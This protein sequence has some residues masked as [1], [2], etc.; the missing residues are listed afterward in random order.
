MKECEL[1]T[2]AME[3]LNSQ[4][5]GDGPIERSV[6]MMTILHEGRNSTLLIR[7]FS[8]YEAGHVY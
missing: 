2:V 7:V 3:T 1:D 4:W 6:E 8:V 5:Q